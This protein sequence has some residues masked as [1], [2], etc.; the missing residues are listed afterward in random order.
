MPK[1]NPSSGPNR[2]FHGMGV[3]S[4][5]R[6]PA[7]PMG[8][9]PFVP[10]PTVR[11]P[12]LPLIARLALHRRPGRETQ[13]PPVRLSSNEPSKPNSQ[14]ALSWFGHL[15][16]GLGEPSQSRGM[17][18]LSPHSLNQTLTSS[19]TVQLLVLASQY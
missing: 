4:Q 3:F 13:L 17:L 6:L 5:F 10:K 18:H 19:S 9:R 1:P 2:S 14:R 15:R 7:I 16:Y 12:K 8:V 11:L